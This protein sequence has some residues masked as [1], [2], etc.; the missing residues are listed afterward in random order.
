MAIINTPTRHSIWRGSIMI[1]KPFF[2]NAKIVT[3]TFLIFANC[4]FDSPQTV[5]V[6]WVAMCCACYIKIHSIWLT[7]WR[8]FCCSAPFPACVYVGWRHWCRWH[9]D[10]DMPCNGGHPHTTN[11]LGEAGARSCHLAHQHGG[12]RVQFYCQIKYTRQNLT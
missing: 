1:K 11:E 8:W 10:T 5:L 3:V 12:Y 2:F 6:L 7:G 9:R 4:T